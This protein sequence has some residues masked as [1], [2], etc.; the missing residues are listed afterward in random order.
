MDVPGDSLAFDDEIRELGLIES[1]AIVVFRPNTIFLVQIK[2]SPS[3]G[4]WIIRRHVGRCMQRRGSVR[5]IG[6][7]VDV[8]SQNLRL[9]TTDR[10]IYK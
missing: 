2:F 3:H 7:D 10:Y 9:C 8:K 5:K 4:R 6:V 1:A